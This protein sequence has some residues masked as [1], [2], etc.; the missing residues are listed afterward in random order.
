MRQRSNALSKASSLYLK[1]HQHNPV[2]WIE[3]S[4]AIF[5]RARNEQ[6]LLL[7]SIGYAACHWC[8]VMEHECF[9]DE[10][11]AQLMNT[12]YICVKVDREERP[13][14]DHLYMDALQLMTGSGGWPLNVVTLS[15]GRPFW[16]ATYLPK[17]RWMNALRDLHH[18]H[19]EDPERVLEYATQLS[20]GLKAMAETPSVSQEEFH[21]T[22]KEL[23][24]VKE[25]FLSQIDP[26]NGGF[27]GAP[28]FMMPNTLELALHLNHLTPD[29]R[30]LQHLR[31]TLDRMSYGS[32]FDPI[33]GGFAR[34]SVDAKWHVVHF[35]K[36]AYDN[37]Q[38]LSLYAKAYAVTK[39]KWYQ[40]VCEQ[41][42]VFFEKWLFDSASGG[43]YSALD[44]DSLNRHQESEEGAYYTFTREE[45]QETLGAQFPLFEKA[46]SINEIGHWE[47]GNYLLYRTASF[48]TLANTLNLSEEQVI[49]EIEKGLQKLKAFQLRRAKPSCDTKIITSWNALVL[50][51]FAHCLRYLDLESEIK[52]K[53]ITRTDA[54]YSLLSERIQEDNCLIRIRQ[55]DENNIEGFLEDYAL[56]I[57]GLLDYGEVTHRSEMIDKAD[58]LTR[59]CL[60]HFKEPQGFFYFTSEHQRKLVRR[61]V[62]LE[63]NVISSSNAIMARNLLRLAVLLRNETFRAHSAQMCK[64]I[65]EQLKAHPRSYSHWMQASLNHIFDFHEIAVIGP[66]YELE[67]AQI[68]ARYLPNSALAAATKPS[69]P[70]LLNQEVHLDQ[71][72]IFAC[73]KGSCSLPVHSS[74][75]L[76]TQ[77]KYT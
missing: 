3:Y 51:G 39:D 64:N 38:L 40:K 25:N 2:D 72:T 17:E 60:D 6:K 77:L 4:D 21:W 70:G 58:Q 13:D 33:N 10:E 46:Y 41:T 7:F 59:Y 61:T 43:Y 69:V 35:E 66:N 45:L 31:T 55:P 8:H 71:T 63:D 57:Q 37:A 75:A 73:I 42:L 76:F 26:V 52:N 67:V 56:T 9:E 29:E 65:K 22:N 11:V 28:K 53:L 20:N 5:E 18:L 47:N 24:E 1:Q 14:I 49:Y 62:E 54:L 23:E 15:D 74:E 12:H 48:A 27:R 44:A 30:L 16:G 36:M 19:T 34:Y 68:A 50:S 32:L